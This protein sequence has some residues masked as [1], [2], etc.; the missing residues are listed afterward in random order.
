MYGIFN[1]SEQVLSAID[2]DLVSFTM[3][4]YDFDLKPQVAL[5]LDFQG[6]I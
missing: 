4:V 6:Q 5:T 2:R 3:S 1:R